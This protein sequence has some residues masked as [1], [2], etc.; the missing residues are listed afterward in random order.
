MV[1]LFCTSMEEMIYQERVAVSTDNQEAKPDQK[2]YT[3]STCIKEYGFKR[4]IFGRQ[5]VRN[6]DTFGNNYKAGI[7]NNAKY[8]V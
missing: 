7:K 1:N 4:K 3:A 8:R 2:A 5:V 6:W